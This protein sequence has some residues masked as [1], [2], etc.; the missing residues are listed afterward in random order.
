MKVG[1]LSFHFK[2]LTMKKLIFLFL[3]AITYDVSSQII[4]FPDEQFRKAL[5]H[6]KCVDVNDDGLGDLNADLNGDGQIQISE[7]L[8]V[9]RLI[10]PNLEINKID[11]IE[12]FKNLTYLVCN[13]NRLKT[14]TLPGLENLKYLKCDN[15]QITQLDLKGLTKLQFL[16]CGRNSL[17]NLEVNGLENLIELGCDFN[18]IESFDATEL[19]N[20]KALFCSQNLLSNLNVVGLSK[21]RSLYCGNNKL[22][23]LNLD[24]LA[25]LRILAT[26]NNR[27]SFLNV[28]GMK[29]LA[30]LSCDVNYLTSID[31]KGLD[32]I[33][34]ISCNYNLISTLDVSGLKNLT[35]LSCS[36]SQLTLLN[37]KGAFNL[38]ALN[39][40]DNKIN[41]LDVSELE[42][43]SQLYCQNNQLISLDVQKC[44]FLSVLD[45]S[46]NKLTELDVTG[47]QYLKILYCSENELKSLLMK[48]ENLITTL[49][50]KSN[51]NLAYICCNENQ[52]NEIK[53]KAVSNGIPNC[54]VSSYCS[55]QSGKKF[56][57]VTGNIKLD[58]NQ[59]GC[60]R[61]GLGYSLLTINVADG[62]A[63]GI[64]LPNLNGTYS[65]KVQEGT[66]TIT[67]ILTSADSY[68]IIPKSF[69]F[70]FPASKDSISQNFCVSLKG[71]LLQFSDINFKKAI[72]NDIC[73]DTND[74][75]I[76]DSD[77]DINNDNEISVFEAAKIKRLIL[78]NNPT[79]VSLDD[80]H[81]FINLNYLS[82]ENLNKLE[83]LHL[84]NVPLLH[85]IY[86]N[87]LGSID[88]VRLENLSSLTK[89]YIE[90]SKIRK[91]SLAG[92]IVFDSLIINTTSVDE[93]DIQ[94]LDKLSN[95]DFSSLKDLK[96]FEIFNS[97]L[98]ANLQIADLPKL[99]RINC[100]SN[101]NLVNLD[102]RNAE[103]LISLDCMSG[104]L[105]SI[106]VS[107][108]SSLAFLGC[109]IN[110]LKS[111]K[112]EKT[113]SLTE[114]SC[115]FN[116]LENL[117][118]NGL[119]NLQYLACHD[120]KLS[121]LNLSNLNKLVSLSCFQNLIETLDFTNTK[122]LTEIV[123][124]GNNIRRLDL[125]AFENLTYLDF[126]T[127]SIDQLDLG[128]S[129]NIWYLD[130]SENLLTS[131][132]VNHLDSLVFLLLNNNLLDSL[133]LTNVHR[134][135]QINLAN[136]GMKFL[137]IEDIPNVDVLDCSDNKLKSLNLNSVK[138]LYQLLL[139]ENDLGEL[140]IKNGN[141]DGTE[142]LNLEKNPNLKYICIDEI[143]EVYVSELLK[144]Q[145]INNV[146]LNT[147]CN[148]SKT[149]SKYY[150]RGTTHY[151]GNNNGCDT[152][153]TTMPNL[154]LKIKADTSSYFNISNGS[155]KY[156]IFL[157]EGDYTLTPIVPNQQHFMISP[158]EVVISSAASS[159]TITQNFCITPKGIFRQINIT[160][161]PLTPP[162]RPGFD[163]SY[164]IIWENAGNQLESGT[165]NFMYNE[166]LLDYIRATQTPNQIVNS[167][168]SW[169]FINLLPFEKREITITLKVNKP[170]DT[171]PVN[172]GDKLYFKAS[173]KDHIFTLENTVVGSYDP[174]DKTCLQGERIKPE[175][176]GKSV[177]Y[178]IRFE[179]TGNYA[180]ENVVI[181]DIIDA[182]RFDISTLQI[183][184][185]SHQMYTRI[186]GNKVEFI[187]ENINL[188]FDDANNDGYIA[189][190]IKTLSTLVVGDSLKNKADIYFDYNFP[191][192][193]N[194]SQSTIN[195]PVSSTGDIVQSVII[196]PNPVSDILYLQTN[197]QWTKAEI[198][199]ISGR[200]I[201]Q[202]SVD[203]S[204]LDVSRLESGLYLA[205][206]F[207]GT[208]AGQIKF[209]KL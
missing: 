52:I 101:Q 40:N 85:T 69:T 179:N 195:N 144:N 166:G 53:N 205:R 32:S 135:A 65:I 25:D 28:Q 24:G 118:L 199:D 163:A 188:P 26:N 108:A 129:K 202:V 7:A 59:N 2:K 72:I 136:N 54:E 194:E 9:E 48:T 191:I 84:S 160:I 43:L 82:I 145:K 17:S 193:T 42:K 61:D 104:S 164:K 41:K 137:K 147:Y 127:N 121:T 31:L 68:E 38:R 36:Y 158:A 172:A 79:I 198:Y 8:K 142:I 102:I 174:N 131:L 173:I 178:L 93:L 97:D 39:C 200:I 206:L 157:K 155:G 3:L 167:M 183:T 139:Q 20:L 4:E 120:N 161:I 12:N 181:T 175:M 64:T 67:P 103:S 170:T 35:Q 165:L 128:P 33:G 81:N 94:D 187:F 190:K 55:F 23:G 57:F 14:I 184:N 63:S 56:Y 6:T 87:A 96:S 109:S 123:C 29:K 58:V 70:T 143:E 66:H 47:L 91:L 154:K 46:K 50:I 89:F 113:E 19:K 209:V 74:D 98:I 90:K 22:T 189:F 153:D 71:S 111:L 201:R 208:K 62:T 149:G 116:L 204:S 207:N 171:P 80:I 76:P 192:R 146:E 27:L 100:S 159:D 16:Y 13:S 106:S 37:I 45:C 75:N 177:D 77:A 151:D 162:A 196:Y 122:E 197:E 150:V 186:N 141:D 132:D 107:N 105:E 30:Y 125:S 92:L 88:I 78:K 203:R 134:L 148:F 21:L 110:R 130:G 99:D 169:N 156:S 138:V 73:I 114:L 182:K 5:A 15:N 152:L 44:K 34:F 1:N 10:V 119:P 95:I 49:A 51:P 126:H 180:A 18:Q 115:G 168:V 60:E 86:C 133:I 185:A 140:F 11:G 176:I 112:L 117:D 83:N 124:S